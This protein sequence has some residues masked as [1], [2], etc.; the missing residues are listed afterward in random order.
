MII[1]R[2]E[3]MNKVYVWVDWGS[4]GLWV[5]KRGD[6]GIYLANASYERFGLPEDLVRRFEYWT[7]W[8]DNRKFELRDIKHQMDYKL[9]RAYGLSLAC[10]LKLFLKD[11]YK[12]FYGHKTDHDCTEI[13]LVKRDYDDAYVPWTKEAEQNWEQAWKLDWQKK[14]D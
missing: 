7:A 13:V 9:F 11:T 8:F 5:P 4:T 14:V 2:N 3:S 1:Q 12:V 10:D 6:S